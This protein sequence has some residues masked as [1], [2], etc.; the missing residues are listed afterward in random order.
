LLNICDTWYVYKLTR[1]FG[2]KKEL[3]LFRNRTILTSAFDFIVWDE[4]VTSVFLLLIM[5]IR[6]V[7]TGGAFESSLTN[8][9]A[10]V[11]F[12]G[13]NILIDCGHSV[14]PKLNTLNL[15][16]TID[17]VLITHLHDDHVGS[18]SSFILYH[19]IILQKGKLK[20][21]LGN[22]A[23]GDELKAFLQHSLR[24]VDA[25]VDFE[26]ASEQDGIHVIDT[27]GRHVPG[28]QTFG[29]CFSDGQRSIAY[30]GDNGDAN[31]F[32]E[33]L[34]KLHLPSL[35]VFHEMCYFEGLRAH[36]HFTDLEPWL[37]KYEIYGYH[38]DHRL[39]PT[40][41]RIPLVGDFPELNV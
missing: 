37:K 41:N 28:M 19:S 2:Q 12:R 21:F 15:L 38:C 35:M 7:G 11:S 10:I 32:F 23:F 24:N 26:L 25:Y 27:F 13:K 4:F 5:E 18:L 16:S 22:E 8:S 14:F 39:A 20:I 33:A 3:K 30:S 17:A 1:F 36:P 34:E 6:F 40:E 9:S 31:Y 29:Y